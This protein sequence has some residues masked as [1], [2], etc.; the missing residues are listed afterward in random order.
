MKALQPQQ[1]A[2]I[3][4]ASS[5]IGK[6]FALALAKR[7]LHVILVARNQPRLQ[8]LAEEIVA[9]GGT[10]DVLSADLQDREQMA[11]VE[12]RLRSQ[13]AVDLFI[14]NAAMGISGKFSDI[15]IDDAE[16]QININVIAPTRLA[17]AAVRAMKA[18]GQGRIINVSSGTAFVPSLYNAAYSGTKSYLSTLSL[19]ISEELKG[20]GVNVL[21]VYPGFTRTEFQQRAN[22]KVKKVP[23]YLWQTA[24]DVAEEALSA[25]EAGKTLCV[26]GRHNRVAI[27]LNHLVPYSLMGKYAGWIARLTPQ[28]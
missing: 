7:K 27:A 23:N 14:N 26:P 25:M 18:R 19:T 13:P 1:I 5:G 15:E 10:A 6:A 2:L 16:T 17:H 9:L 24:S 4:G 3:T 20:T 21:T 11:K 12:T 22:F 28:G 8:Q